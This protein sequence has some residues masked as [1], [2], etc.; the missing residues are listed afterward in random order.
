[1]RFL[2]ASTPLL[3]WFGVLL[4]ALSGLCT[5]ASASAATDLKL[6]SAKP[7]RHKPTGLAI[8][9]TLAGLPRDR[10]EALTPDLDEFV[11]F[12]SADG[13]EDITVY[14]F[15]RTNGSVP[16]WADRVAWQI[17]HR[18]IYGNA[19][20]A[21]PIAAFTPPGQASASGLIGIYNPGKG[22]YRSTSFAFMP[23]GD[24]WYIAFRYSSATLSPAEL[25]GRLR[26]VIATVQWPKRIQAQP[27]AAAIGDCTT[28]LAL[29]GPAN[30]VTGE[31]E[32]AVTLASVAMLGV[33]DEE[34]KGAKTTLASTIGWCRD[35]GRYEGIGGHGV[36]RPLD[37]T[38]RYLLALGD[39]GVGVMVAPNPLV[40][41][42][43]PKG[44]GVG[45]TP[46]LF[47]L[48][49]SIVYQRRDRLPAPDQLFRIIDTEGPEATITTW[50]KVS[51][52]TI[53]THQKSAN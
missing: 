5:S 16:I 23:L 44:V 31:S 17:E 40:A 48:A 14:V 8:P 39:A 29:S 27:A 11:E 41:E 37:T 19:S 1:M 15:R 38:D 7:Y 2:L 35:P 36:Y 49:R 50:G 53:N 10:A 46:T 3:R 32:M 6:P 18:D 43:M 22:R 4:L 52:I 21:M 24:E 25:D 33:L 34:K 9:P 47:G 42:L 28:P 30:V 12:R 20:L 45:W 26:E 51:K 13:G